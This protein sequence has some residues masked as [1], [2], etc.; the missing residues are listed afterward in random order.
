MSRVS[1][2]FSRPPATAMGP[3]EED[4]SQSVCAKYTCG[5]L[6]VVGHCEEFDPV[7]VHR[8]KMEEKDFV[9]K[10][11]VYDIVREERVPSHS[12]HVGHGKHGVG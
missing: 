10:M 6:G 2:T 11:G 1:L 3:A 4:K 7:L 8:A 5:T 9:D 12:H